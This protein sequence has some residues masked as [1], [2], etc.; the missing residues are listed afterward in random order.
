MQW[1]KFRIISSGFGDPVAISTWAD[2]AMYTSSCGNGSGHGGRGLDHT[3]TISSLLLRLVPQ[4]L[5]RRFRE[6]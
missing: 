1:A 3:G 2:E 4:W 5:I 6:W